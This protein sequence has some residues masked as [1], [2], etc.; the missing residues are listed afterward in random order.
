MSTTMENDT[1]QGSARGAAMDPQFSQPELD[2][3]RETLQSGANPNVRELELCGDDRLLRRALPEMDEAVATTAEALRLAFTRALRGPVTLAPQRVTL[4]LVDEARA[5]EERIH[6]RLVLVGEPGA[7]DLPLLMDPAL[8]FL[9]VQREFGGSLEL[10]PVNRQ[11]LTGLERSLL[12]KLGPLL[13][14]ALN[15][16]LGALGLKLRVR[17]APTRPTVA[18]QWPRQLSVLALSWRLTVGQTTGDLHLLVPPPVIEALRERFSGERTGQRDQRWQRAMTEQ[19]R[20]VE[21]EVVAELGRVHSTL[22]RI[23]AWREGEV[24]RLERSLSEQIPVSIDGRV[25]L[26]GRPGTRGD[27]VT[28]T[29]EEIGES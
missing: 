26:R 21:I 18:S 14:E 4:M 8:V 23:M 13:T 6:G 1:P 7:C 11:E 27:T 15:R 12:L 24:L 2:A 25:K 28:L 19:L 16:G 10:S 17:G 20:L 29:I 5:L 22:T 9:H 3:L